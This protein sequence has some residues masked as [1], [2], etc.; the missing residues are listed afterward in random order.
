MPDRT[1]E[2]DPIPDDTLEGLRDRLP[3]AAEAIEEVLDWIERDLPAPQATRRRFTNGMRAITTIVGY[4]EWLIIC[5]E[6]EP[7]LA[8][9][10]HI[11]ESASL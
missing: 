5:D 2:L 7:N 6:P 10:G 3:K 8:V 11:G 9:I 4:E 1:L